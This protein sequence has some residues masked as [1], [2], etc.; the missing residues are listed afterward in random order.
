MGP[1][2]SALLGFRSALKQVDYRMSDYDN[3]F[4]GAQIWAGK[5]T[6]AM[7]TFL[8]KANFKDKKVWL[9]ITKADP[10]VNQAV[11]DSITQ[12]VEKKGGKVI[13]CLSIT[14]AWD[15]KK[16]IPIAVDQVKE[17]VQEWIGGILGN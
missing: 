15:P 6:P 10:K 14:A 17:P 3:I 9:F 8:S 2:L 4:L 7:N 1:A 16:N 12:R 13:D 5:T 11:I